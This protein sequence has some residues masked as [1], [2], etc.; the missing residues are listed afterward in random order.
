MTSVVSPKISVAPA[1]SAALLKRQGELGAILELAVAVEKND[2]G[3]I[4]GLLGRLG[5]TE[6]LLN[7]SLLNSYQKSAFLLKS[8]REGGLG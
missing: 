4:D 2:L 5:L 8:N 1:I 7:Q 3:R 6:R